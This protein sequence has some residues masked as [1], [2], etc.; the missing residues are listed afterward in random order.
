MRRR[1]P[2]E[3]GGDQEATDFYFGGV[4]RFDDEPVPDV[5]VSV[6]GGGFEAETVTDADGR[7]RLYVPEKEDYTLTI[8]ESTLPE[9]VIVD[10]GRD[11]GRR[12][13]STVRPHELRDHQP[14]PRR[15]RTA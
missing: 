11:S 14:L 7:W 12:R 10:P 2:D 13:T 6:E 8:D 4:I 9:G 1:A 3:P 5:V 15:G